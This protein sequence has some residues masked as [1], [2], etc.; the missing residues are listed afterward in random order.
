[1]SFDEDV[2]WTPVRFRASPPHLLN[3]LV[4]LIIMKKL[5]SFDV[6][7]RELMY[8]GSKKTPQLGLIFEFLKQFWYVIEGR[9]DME[10]WDN[11]RIGSVDV[12]LDQDGHL[13]LDFMTRFHLNGKPK[14]LEFL[15]ALK[16]K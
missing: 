5:F 3:N 13:H 12:F 7:L 2:S 15:D 1:M 14:T 11:I 9:L 16:D 6:T 4:L 10:R 8:L